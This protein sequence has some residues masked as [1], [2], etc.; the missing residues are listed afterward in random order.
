[1]KKALIAIF[2]PIIL[3][4]L[5]QRVEGQT[6]SNS[7]NAELFEAA[8]T[9][10]TTGVQRLLQNGANLEAK[11][12]LFGNTA[13]LGATRDGKV[14]V[15]KLLLDRGADIEAKDN[16]GYIVVLGC[17]HGRHRRRE[18]LAGWGRKIDAAR[19]NAGTALTWAAERGERRRLST[20]LL[21]Q[22]QP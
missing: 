7:V 9:G 5:S 6:S 19:N 2:C 11:D 20:F 13:L 22:M 1:M 17:C 12:E 3:F 10:D 14:E 15:V 16:T 8:K 18:G 4:S 21:N